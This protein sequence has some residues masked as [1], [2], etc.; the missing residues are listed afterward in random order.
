MG[1]FVRVLP[2]CSGFTH[3]RLNVLLQCTVYLEYK[4][5]TAVNSLNKDK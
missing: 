3:Q 1:I 4:I 2:I 5:H